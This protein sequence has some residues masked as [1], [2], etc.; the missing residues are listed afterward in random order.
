MNTSNGTGKVVHFE[1]PAENMERAQKFYQDVFGWHTI[2][3]PEM[4][5][6]MAHSGPTDDKTGMMKENGFINGGFMQ[7]KDI[8][9]PVIVMDVPNVD[10]AVK[11]A[12]SLGSKVIRPKVK[13]G[14][15]GYVA[16]VTDSE[17]NTIGIWE[18]IPKAV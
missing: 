6:A 16:Y 15:M 17:G 1:V 4:H 9:G 8:K 18:T 13:V 12:E 2:N 7:R 11:K 5:Y 3:L 10:E 14:D